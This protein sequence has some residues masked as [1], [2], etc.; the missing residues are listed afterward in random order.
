[1]HVVV[2]EAKKL[3]AIEYFVDFCCGV[4]YIV[5][6]LEEVENWHY[7]I[8]MGS[9]AIKIGSDTRGG[10][11]YVIGGEISEKSKRSTSAKFVDMMFEIGHIIF[12]QLICDH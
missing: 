7:W 4:S 2:V 10:D 12:W 11:G 5:D 8:P 3:T 1:M 9:Y 6:F